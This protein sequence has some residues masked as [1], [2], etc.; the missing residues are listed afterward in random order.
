M[1]V[2]DKFILFWK[3]NPTGIERCRAL[4][5]HTQAYEPYEDIPFWNKHFHTLRRLDPRL[6]FTDLDE[7][8]DIYFEW[9]RAPAFVTQTETS[10]RFFSTDPTLGNFGEFTSALQS[11]QEKVFPKIDHLFMALLGNYRAKRAR[12]HEEELAFRVLA[13]FDRYET[14]FLDTLIGHIQHQLRDANKESP[15]SRGESYYGVSATVDWRVE[16]VLAQMNDAEP[17]ERLYK[18]IAAIHDFCRCMRFNTPGRNDHANMR[19]PNDKYSLNEEHGDVL[20]DRTKGV[21]VWAG[22]SG[23]AMDM[24]YGAIKVGIDDP[25]ILT[26]FAFCIFAF[27]HFMPTIRSATHTYNEVM[28]GAQSICPKISY[29]PKDPNVPILPH[30]MGL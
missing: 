19:E 21:S 22:K 28:R 2:V 11:T 29:N 13:S 24:I 30:P 17:L 26:H 20:A 15:Y 7:I 16:N 8:N 27:F 5:P 12:A 14:L 9:V 3:A 1:I 4:L 25:D 23:S 10:Y 6:T 18:K